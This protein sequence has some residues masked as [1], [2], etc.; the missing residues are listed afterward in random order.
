VGFLFLSAF[1]VAMIQLFTEST[2]G[3]REREIT[4]NLQRG[5]GAVF[6]NDV[7][8]LRDEARIDG[9]LPATVRE[10]T[11][12]VACEPNGGAIA[13]SGQSDALVP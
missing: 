11:I 6:P 2:R 7:L 1:C 5:F 12:E 13:H 4:Q 3:L 10:P 8:S 9:A